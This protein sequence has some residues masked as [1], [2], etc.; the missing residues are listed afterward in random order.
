M[1]NQ[2]RPASEHIAVVVDLPRSPTVVLRTSALPDSLEGAVAFALTDR[3]RELDFGARRT[4][5][6]KCSQ[7]DSLAITVEGRLRFLDRCPLVLKLGEIAVTR[8]RVRPA[9]RP[10]YLLSADGA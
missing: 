4:N 10:E 2:P 1:P 3:Q 5:L 7:C 6:L 9:S 8:P